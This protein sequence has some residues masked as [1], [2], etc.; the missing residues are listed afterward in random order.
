M[1][2]PEFSIRRNI[3]TL[4]VSLVLILFGVIALDRLGI[5]KFP[6]VEF[7]IVSVVTTMPGADPE[8]V[9]RN[10]TDRIEEVVNQVPGV[11]SI[12]SSSSLSASVV[13]VEFELEKNVDVAYQEV[14]AKVDSILK[15]LPE[16][17][18]PPTVRKVEVGATAVLWLALTG[19]RTLQELNTYADEVIKP[20]LETVT[21]V[22][23]VLVGG[24]IKRTIRAWLDPDRLRAYDLSPLDVAN[25]FRREHITQPAG[26]IETPGR[27]WLIKF[28]AEFSRVSDL[29]RLIV[30]YR[31]GSPVYLRDVA[32]V[33]DGLED[34]RKLA[35]YMGEPAVGLGI[36]KA[37][38]AN[39]VAV[40]DRIKERVDKEIRPS[41]PAGLEIRY[42]SDD[43]IS[44]RQSIAALNEHLVLGTLFAAL[45]VFLFLKSGRSTLI[46]A[47][48]IPVS[49]FATFAVMY[50][51]GYTLNKITLLGLLLLIG[52]VVDD[53][54]VVLENI[55]RHR[56][57]E[58][59]DREI[60]AVAGSNQVIFAVIAST[61]TLVSIFLPVA[62]ITG[63]VGRFLSS[64]ALVVV[65]GVL[66]SLWVSLTLTPMLCARYLNLPATHGRVY[67]VLERAFIALENGYR[68]LLGLALRHRWKVVMIATLVVASSFFP[69]K[70]V[71]KSFVPEE[72]EARFMIMTQAPLGS[73]L[74]YTSR[75]LAEVEAIV[76]KR[77]EVFSF[78][79]AVGLGEAGQVTTGRTF[80]RL[81]DRGE[82]ELS[83]AQIMTELRRELNRIAG[84]Q[85]FPANIS[86]I[87]GQRGEPLQ[88][89]VVGP[90]INQI[91]ELTN[92]MVARLS[93]V[94]GVAKLDNEL[95][96]NLPE[97]RLELDRERAA[98]L[99]IS[100]VDV[101][102]TLNAMTAGLD[103]AE[104]REGS[105]RYDIRLQVE[106]TERASAEI[107]KK[108]Y[109]KNRANELVRLDTLVRIE[110]GVGPAE[111][112]RRNR[113][114]AGFVYGALEG[115]PLGDAA[116]A[117][118]RIA[119]EIL[120]AGYS[121]A[122]AGQAEEFAKTGG[123]IVFAFSLA[124]V[125][126]Y[127]V[128]A[129]QFN[130]FLQPLV[131][132]VAQPLAII[133]GVTALWISSLFGTGDT[134]NLFS[135]IGMILLMGLVAK[136][137][138][139]LVDLTNQYRAAGKSVDEALG[140]A[141]PHR[142][143]PVLITSLTVIAAMMP[144]AIGL[145]PGV[146][147]NR[148]LALVVMGGMLSS[149]MLTLIVVP[150][151]Y[152]L[153]ENALGRRRARRTVAAEP[154]ETAPAWL[155]IARIRRK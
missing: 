141:C 14:K 154:I 34:A 51:A 2:L 38:D 149:T 143:R 74:P 4:M 139:L 145:G 113:Q 105:Q 115:L 79:S 133:G 37:T 125:M 10:I 107:L 18:D 56:E 44:I 7:P 73:N 123:Y 146:E 137:S 11:K 92:E 109:V 70:Y 20:R 40:V 5:D 36:V 150:A 110:E 120:P 32:R 88:F 130:S 121:I 144:A 57:E 50:F 64:F 127:M 90:D 31:Q 24:Q 29:S 152:S 151:V 104:F 81:K 71:G 62:F 119:S 65:I 19:N 26:F 63:I 15:Q 54:I 97:F 21:G 129:S 78:F 53:A 85:A 72:D 49:L 48:A 148:P 61:L 35:R 41:L 47:T 106:P 76:A 1:S 23:E 103:I 94:Q 147:T 69:F 45:L 80:V 91:G 93:Q 132:M 95:K 124:L 17:S 155:R 122:F 12:T 58:H 114:Y 87:G 6:K 8:I 102:Q 135:M 75:K 42:S 89:A 30:A 116:N 25:A 13:A 22:G 67:H 66:V 128:L 43:S 131:V 68:R 16:D 60:A 59:E 96:L 142:M 138:I 82:R 55:F 140:E 39:T 101:A 134:L 3:F 108:I 33:E 27:E 28:D 46:I 153:V 99:G 126:I 52:V 118:N 83:Q 9:D 98:Q 86:P 77:P 84:I 117:V 111:I 112:K 100:A 136:N